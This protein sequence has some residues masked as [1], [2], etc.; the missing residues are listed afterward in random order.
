[1]SEPKVYRH[2]EKYQIKTKRLG[3]VQNNVSRLLAICLDSSIKVWN[4]SIETISKKIF[5][6]N[7]LSL[8]I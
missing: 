3:Y 5:R 6:Y 4:F 1:M 7:Q 8:R 2:D